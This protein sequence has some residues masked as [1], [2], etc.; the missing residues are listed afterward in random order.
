V[1]FVSFT[2]V[3]K[4]FVQAAESYIKKLLPLVLIV[5]LENVQSS[6]IESESIVQINVITTLAND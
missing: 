6:K 2:T 1:V 5:L 3:K 4:T